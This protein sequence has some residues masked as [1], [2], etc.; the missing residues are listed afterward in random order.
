M[1]QTNNLLSIM[2]GA[3]P[4]FEHITPASPMIVSQQSEPGP[5]LLHPS[6]PHW[7]QVSRQQYRPLEDIKPLTPLLHSDGRRGVGD[8]RGAKMKKKHEIHRRVVSHDGGVFRRQVAR[9]ST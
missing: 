2:H 9:Q 1:Y 8:T 7:L 4:V 3:Q 6:P 5:G